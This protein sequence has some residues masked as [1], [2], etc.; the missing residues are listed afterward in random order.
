[1]YENGP[2]W[3]VVNLED[4]AVE[5][6]EFGSGFDS[7]LFFCHMCQTSSQCNGSKSETFTVYKSYF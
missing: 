5:K 4:A 6:Y 1:M 3:L 2:F 7:L